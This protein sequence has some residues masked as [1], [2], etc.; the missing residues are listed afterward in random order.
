MAVVQS[1]RTNVGIL[2]KLTSHL[3]QFC[4]LV[5]KTYKRY[6]QDQNAQKSHIS[7]VLISSVDSQVA[8]P[9]VSLGERSNDKY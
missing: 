5:C 1:C 8:F 7:I 3:C 9:I 6:P 4:F 2:I